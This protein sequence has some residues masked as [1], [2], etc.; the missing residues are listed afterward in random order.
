MRAVRLEGLV[1]ERLGNE[2]M[3]EEEA[4]GG[5]PRAK[6]PNITHT[7][8]QNISRLSLGSSL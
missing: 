7:L 2:V 3:G 6:V 8:T 1:K 5:P 4:V